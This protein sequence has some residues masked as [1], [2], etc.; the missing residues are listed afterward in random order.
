M[1]QFSVF[2]PG[3]PLNALG[4]VFAGDLQGLQPLEDATMEWTYRFGG[5]HFS[6]RKVESNLSAEEWVQARKSEA[7]LA[8]SFHMH[9]ARGSFLVFDLD[10][11]DS[12]RH[13]HP[14]DDPHHQYSAATCP[15]C[16]VGCRHTQG[17]CECCWQIVQ[18]A[19]F[20]TDRLVTKRYSLPRPLYVFSGSGGLH[21]WY[22][23]HQRPEA[24]ATFRDQ[25]ARQ[26]LIDDLR[27]E[28]LLRY[29]PDALN[30]LAR[31]VGLYRRKIPN[32]MIAK[33]ILP[34]F[35]RGPTC[36]AR[37]LIRMPFSKNE[38]QGRYALPLLVPPEVT[39]LPGYPKF[40]DFDYM[41]QWWG[42]SAEYF[43]GWS[44]SP[45]AI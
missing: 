36:A 17:C 11:R 20:L 26:R 29:E 16:F 10:T 27:P 14:E 34:S 35:D 40:D 25:E 24:R 6:T 44:C 4:R 1:D 33:S 30:E 31:N 13:L 42:Q 8:T 5:G 15:G 41:S 3:T 7:P 32:D 9:P 43:V 2:A 37:H 18:A 21:V 45:D 22:R 23:I 38:K 19:I 28:H 39:P 12:T